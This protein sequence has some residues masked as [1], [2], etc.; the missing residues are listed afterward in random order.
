[1]SELDEESN[2]LARGLQEYGIG[3][4]V[5]TVLMVTPGV[6]FFTLTFALFKAGAVPVMVD[7]GM[8]VKKLKKC[9]AEAS[10]EGFVGIAKAHAARVIL[11]WAR[12]SIRKNV[13]V[14]PRLFWGGRSFAGIRS[15]DPSPVLA[16]TA[17]DA[18]AAILFTSGSTGIPKG[19]VYTHEMFQAQVC[20]LRDFYGIGPG[21]RDLATFPLFALFGPALGMA[22][23][24]PR[25]DASRPIT[26]DPRNL[27]AA[28]MDHSATNFFASPALIEVIGRHGADRDLKLDS[29]KRVISA[30]APATAES[31]HR[32]TQLLPDGVEIYPSYGA[33]EALPVASIGSNELLN[34]TAALTEEGAGVCVGRA[35]GGL[36]I[37]IIGIDDG[38]IGDWSEDLNI[39]DGEI[40]EIC[41]SGQV[42]SPVYY[43]R[44]ESTALAKIIDW[45]SGLLYH[46]MGD[47]GYLDAEGRLWFCGR[48]AH[49]VE[50]ADKTYFTIPCERIFNTHA[51]VFRSALVGVFLGGHLAPAICVERETSHSDGDENGLKEELRALADDHAITRG[52]ETFLFHKGF[53]MDVRHN[54]K[55]FREQLAVWVQEQLP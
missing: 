22:A 30:G 17:P 8:G 52:I 26:A 34:D 47:V 32:F 13:T 15:G 29:L 5:R 35:A 11:G 45:D 6:A 31:L 46:R 27:V 23:I 12:G 7:P 10:P 55:I 9:F 36:R 19:V 39:P 48:K 49:R 37:R 4:G 44:P 2:R 18:L 20:V 1:A 50:T 33:T 24:V 40:G 16:E 21:E 53:P 54:A 38:P 14:G 41:V 43:E 25:M 42:V 28:T 3:E 51:E